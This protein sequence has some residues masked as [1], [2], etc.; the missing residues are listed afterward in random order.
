[1][2]SVRARPAELALFV[3]VALGALAL[4]PLPGTSDTAFWER[5]TSA[6]LEHG[7]RRAYVESHD[8]YPPATLALFLASARLG[9]LAGLGVLPS[10]KLSLWAALLATGAVAWRR[11]GRPRDGALAMAIL[12][13]GA[14]ALAYTDVYLA[15]LLLLAFA[16]LERDRW[17]RCAV[18]FTLAA[19]CKWLPLVVAP[20]LLAYLLKR[21][22]GALPWR[23]AALEAALPAAA[24]VALAVAL[25]GA[26]SLATLGRA[27]AFDPFLSGNALNLG[28]VVTHLLRATGWLGTPGLVAGE[29]SYLPTE[30]PRLTLPL[31][32][33]FWLA[34]AAVVVSFLRAPANFRTLL[35]HAR[36]AFLAYFVLATRVH[37]NHLF[38]A[39]VLA[40]ALA[41]SAPGRWRP[42][43]VWS[44]AY[45]ANLLLFYGITGEGPGVSRVVA[46]V[47]AAVLAAAAV[48]VLF[49]REL[50]GLLSGRGR[51]GSARAAALTA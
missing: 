33:A 1:M 21:R 40:G 46:G 35:E 2:P 6:A 30:D 13:P 24:V 7:F 41:L 44:G 17:R 48:C 10:I 51:N 43:A 36:V 45:L 22:D 23:R 50:A 4:V 3:L 47:D 38:V 42:L 19:L 34:Y 14:T 27:R 12:A 32:A 39:V 5:W 15:P 8:V 37:E 20:L 11:S 25:A 29:A 16:A 9:A 31:D 28:W 49:A 18:L 26:E